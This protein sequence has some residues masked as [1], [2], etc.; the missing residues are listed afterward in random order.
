MGMDSGGVLPIVVRMK[1]AEGSGS[2]AA[3]WFWVIGL[4][5]A[6]AVERADDAEADGCQADG[7]TGGGEKEGVFHWV[8]PFRK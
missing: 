1:R 2:S 6:A 7:G 3:V 4:A 5:D 8:M